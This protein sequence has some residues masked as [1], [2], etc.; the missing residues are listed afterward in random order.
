[1]KL[2][3]EKPNKL[4]GTVVESLNESTG[5]S[6]KDYFIEGIFSS[7]GVTNRNGRTYDKFIWEREVRRYNNEV[8]NNPESFDALCEKEHPDRAEVDEMAAVAKIVKLT[9]EGD[10]VMG[11]AKILNNNSK[12]TNQIKTLIDEGFRIGVSSRG[13]G[14]VDA[15]GYVNEDFNL[16]T[17]DIV[18]KP[19]D[20]SAVT[21]GIYESEESQELDY[22]VENG[23]VVKICSKDK[24]I[25]S[26]H[27]DTS[28]AVLQKFGEL[29][30]SFSKKP[31]PTTDAE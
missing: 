31:E 11:K 23:Q 6:N 15:K 17:Y 5:T 14:S 26:T 4:K 10:F 27:E 2:M 21:K 20:R 3:L 13:V 22:E 29:M 8:L 19:S 18:T 24:C 12:E 25:L 16:I 30:N 9:M 7:A 1:M 28:A